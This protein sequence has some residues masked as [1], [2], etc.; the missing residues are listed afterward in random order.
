MPLQDPFE[1]LSIL[2]ICD[3]LILRLNIIIAG[4]LI[5][6][7]GNANGDSQILYYFFIYNAL[8]SKHHQLFKSMASTPI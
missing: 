6:N 7:G 5:T 2:R 1:V 4:S 8:D 3:N